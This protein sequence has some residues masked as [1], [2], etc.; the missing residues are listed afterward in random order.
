MDLNSLSK[1]TRADKSKA[2]L[3]DDVLSM[4]MR[5]CAPK[6]KHQFFAYL[7]DD[8]SDNDACYKVIPQTKFC[9]E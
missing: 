9:P 5:I 8:D 3:I 2:K 1:Y 7:A 4:Q 6:M